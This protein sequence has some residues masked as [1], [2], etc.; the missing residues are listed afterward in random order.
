[1]KK[2]NTF[3]Y[4]AKIF[5]IKKLNFL[6]RRTHFMKTIKRKGSSKFKCVMKKK[7]SFLFAFPV[8]SKQKRRE[9]SSSFFIQ[10]KNTHLWHIFELWNHRIEIKGSHFFCTECPYE[11]QAKKCVTNF[12]TCRKLNQCTSNLA[13]KQLRQT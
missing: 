1:M 2:E 12:E 8:E 13:N 5:K 3:F 9:N 11:F 6:D 7:L 4:F 10:K